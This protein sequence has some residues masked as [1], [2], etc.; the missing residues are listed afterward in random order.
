MKR[1][2]KKNKG[3]TLIEILIGVGIAGLGL[4]G[5]YSLYSMTEKS[6]VA[7]QEVI[8]LV[9]YL[10]AINATVSTNGDYS[11][12]SIPYLEDLGVVVNQLNG[13][14]EIDG[15][16]G[17]QLSFMYRGLDT[18]FCT[19]FATAV[20]SSRSDFD[21][22]VAGKEI[23]RD[24]DPVSEIAISCASSGLTDVTFRVET[25]TTVNTLTDET[26]VPQ[27][28]Y[29][30][31]NPNSLGG[32]ALTLSQY[33]VVAGKTSSQTLYGTQGMGFYAG[34][35]VSTPYYPPIPE[36]VSPIISDKPSGVVNEDSSEDD[37]SSGS[38]NVTLPENVE[39]A[40][41]G[42]NISV[43]DWS[44][45]NVFV[46][47]ISAEIQGLIPALHY[48][49]E[50]QSRLFNLYTNNPVEMGDDE[51][52]AP[53]LTMSAQAEN[54]GSV[55]LYVS[56]NIDVSS[57]FRT[58]LNPIIDAERITNPAENM[59]PSLKG[60]LDTTAKNIPMTLNV[61]DEASGFKVSSTQFRPEITLPA[62]SPMNLGDEVVLADGCYYDNNNF[63]LKWNSPDMNNTYTLFV[64]KGQIMKITD[65]N[66]PITE[67]YV[68]FYTT[69]KFDGSFPYTKITSTMEIAA[70]RYS[71]VKSFIQS[72]GLDYN[73]SGNG[74][75]GHTFMDVCF[76]KPAIVEKA[77]TGNYQNF[78]LLSGT[79]EP[80]S[81]ISYNNFTT[82]LGLDLSKVRSVVYTLGNT[83]N[84]T[85]TE[86]DKNRLKIEYVNP[87]GMENTR[88]DISVQAS[89]VMKNGERY[90][91]VRTVTLTSTK[92][93]LSRTE[94]EN[95]AGY[96]T[97]MNSLCYDSG[98]V[99]TPVN[100]IPGTA[101]PPVFVGVNGT[102]YV[103]G[104]TSSYWRKGNNS[105]SGAYDS[106]VDIK[107]VTEMD[108]QSI[109]ARLNSSYWGSS[110]YLYSSS[111]S[112]TRVFRYGQ[113]HGE[114]WGDCEDVI[115]NITYTNGETDTF[116]EFACGSSG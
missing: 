68:G 15:S 89:I 8:S 17:N 30:A 56:E 34:N 113:Y 48:N 5:I 27:F 109:T 73:F 101:L 100:G 47:A 102:K 28:N 116:T 81:Q 67:N 52:V 94:I 69:D 49:F 51:I 90:N 39:F 11:R 12:V 74:G 21:V 106:G 78:Y 1:I 112:R 19:K 37:G 76:K 41:V 31:G 95:A 80:F 38:K 16:S 6:S 110:V 104:V 64:H 84:V 75:A 91:A 50:V 108:I 85:T 43:N 103:S 92:N 99:K 107:V 24:L 79:E 13:L 54:T 93:Q 18:G 36:N 55:L 2:N 35:N 71:S 115:F 60:F 66:G 59:N 83:S 62:S 86:I 98:G 9:S 22:F 7:Q 10:D 96:P 77:L 42:M 97:C 26:L 23:N 4:V 114:G 14:T 65:K 53:E 82:D 72:L 88:Q 40:E 61:I 87:T 32:Q 44:K 63:S 57:Y 3:F 20:M 105:W 33:Q 111:G 46:N 70:D 29:N 58:N 45:I 25:N